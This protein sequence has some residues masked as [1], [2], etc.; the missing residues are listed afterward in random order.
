M[1]KF[2]L[3]LL[4]IM[5]FMLLTTATVLAGTYYVDTNN[6][7]ASD[8]ASGT[9][10]SPWKTIR[11][12]TQTAKA[13]DTVYIK[14]GNY[15][16]KGSGVRHKPA[17]NPANSGRPGSPITFEGVANEKVNITMSSSS[18]PV[19]GVSG[20]DHVIW[21]NLTVTESP[22]FLTDCGTTIL[23]GT[24]NSMLDGIE[25]IGRNRDQMDN[26]NG[27]YINETNHST[28]RN[29]TIHGYTASNNS[30]A[31]NNSGV[32][33]Y[34]STNNTFE[35]NTFYDCNALI[36]D[37][38]NGGNNI[39]RYNYFH[40]APRGILVYGGCHG[41]TNSGDRIYQNIFRNLKTVGIDLRHNINDLQIHNN[42]FYDID[43]AS[44]YGTINMS[45]TGNVSKVQIWNNVF[46]DSNR[47]F[48]FWHSNIG[49][50]SFSDYNSFYRSSPFLVK[51]S[52]TG[53]GALSGWKGY[54]D[55][56]SNSIEE[57]P[58]FVSAGS[59]SPQGY[60][61]STKSPLKNAGRDGV[62]IGAYITGKEV[63]GPSSQSN[64]NDDDKHSKEP[65]TPVN[66]R[67]VGN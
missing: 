60:K 18:G 55:K 40:S 42:T 31:H 32:T 16:V 1:Y 14:G 15:T 56:D 2:K 24:S 33:M 53:N 36:F 34:S 47:P 6:P 48:H 10:K 17:L 41:K 38:C 29:C 13:G 5:S 64:P 59:D 8:S 39:I 44:D 30:E 50:V 45:S 57:N 58:L 37:K 43:A 9:A 25:I 19:I 7:K 11:K 49:I 12:A 66:L 65:S 20:R 26:H 46:V 3:V 62:T 35:N 63:I 61:L 21:R 22:K 67:I 27:I 51:W 52:S 23:W 28:I 4:V 54:S